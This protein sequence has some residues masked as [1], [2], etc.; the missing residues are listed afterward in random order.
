MSNTVNAIITDRICQKIE[1]AI[2]NNDVLPWQKP[3]VWNNAPKNYAGKEYRGINTL[4]LDSGKYITW[5]Q[6][7][8]LKKHNPDIKLKKGCKK[9]MVVYFNFKEYD[10]E[11]TNEKGEKVN[12]KKLVPFLRYYNVYNIKYVEGLEDEAEEKISFQHEPIEE[13]EKIF[14]GYTKAE[15]IKVNHIDGNTA[16][17]SPMTDQITLP[18]IS[19]FENLE[20]Y[21]LTA[22]HEA[23]HSTM[24]RVGRS[25]KGMFGD[26]EY[27]KEELVAE[28]TATMLLA[29]C[30][31]NTVSSEQNSVAYMRGWLKALKDNT[32]WLVSACSQA[33]KATN[34]ILEKSKYKGDVSK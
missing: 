8:D 20:E 17:Y 13:A 10:N 21:Y 11:T 3:W 2:K 12:E 9:D 22:F 26:S 14:S 5:T 19:Q 7:C 32:N 29:Q 30:G 24:S 15:K 34:Y 4:L 28:F 6:I 25:A 33:E 27:S 16:C 1:T 31:I 18:L 23:G